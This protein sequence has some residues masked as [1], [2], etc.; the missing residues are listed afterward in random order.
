VFSIDVRIGKIEYPGAFACLM[1]I[2]ERNNRR[3]APIIA[4]DAPEELATPSVNYARTRFARFV[5]HGPGPNGWQYEPPH[6][7]ISRD[8]ARRHGHRTRFVRPGT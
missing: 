7:G 4:P 8:E 5:E 3:F 2:G 1:I 6:D